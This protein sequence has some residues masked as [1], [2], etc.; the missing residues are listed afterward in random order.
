MVDNSLSRREIGHIMS[1]SQYE[2]KLGSDSTEFTFP[3]AG[4]AYDEQKGDDAC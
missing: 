4:S 2:L 1:V 3:L